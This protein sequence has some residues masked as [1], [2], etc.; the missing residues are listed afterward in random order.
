MV[1]TERVMSLQRVS[2]K[3][4]GPRAV[5]EPHMGMLTIQMKLYS[6]Q[7]LWLVQLEW[8]ILLLVAAHV[9]MASFLLV[10]YDPV[11][12]HSDSSERRGGYPSNVSLHLW[13]GV[14]PFP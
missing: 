3:P 14:G 10:T 13:T 12:A 6:L 8:S 2:M 5:V 1:M 9:S 7:V 11:Q 4:V